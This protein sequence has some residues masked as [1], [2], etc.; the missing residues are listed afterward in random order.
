MRVI[1]SYIRSELNDLVTAVRDCTGFSQK[2]LFIRIY[3]ITGRSGMIEVMK[4]VK[5][6]HVRA[7]RD[8]RWGSATAIGPLGAAAAAG[9]AGGLAAELAGGA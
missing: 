4:Q 8:G 7:S 1:S 5:K 6:A 9:L 3:G 2:R